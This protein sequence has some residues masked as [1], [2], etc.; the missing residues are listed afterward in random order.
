[1][2]SGIYICY[3]PVIGEAALWCPGYDALTMLHTFHV[4]VT[5]ISGLVF[6]RTCESTNQCLVITCCDQ[7]IILIPSYYALP[8]FRYCIISHIT[9]TFVPSSFINNAVSHMHI[10]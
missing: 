4:E 7:P 1:M 10:A 3:M 9:T 6:M 2:I 8:Q 5:H